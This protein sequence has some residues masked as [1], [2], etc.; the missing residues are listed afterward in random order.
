MSPVKGPVQPGG[1]TVEVR[2]NPPRTL[3]VR[4]RDGFHTSLEAVSRV[5]GQPI[6]VR[7]DSVTFRID[8]WRGGS[9]VSDHAPAW[10]QTV[11]SASDPE[12]AFFRDRLSLTKNL[13]FVAITVGL[14]ALAIGQAA[15]AYRYPTSHSGWTEASHSAGKAQSD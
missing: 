1:A 13:L 14:V 4:D 15:V 12:V 9:P 10:A 2:I 5:R 7:G 8:S 3:D 11:L 6:S